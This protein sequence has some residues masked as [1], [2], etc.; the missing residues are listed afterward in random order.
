MI[1]QTRV[2][3]E[4]LYSTQVLK[5]NLCDSMMLT[6]QQE[7]IY[8]NNE[9]VNTNNFN[10]F[11]YKAKS[12][13]NTVADG[14]YEILRNTTIALQIMYL[15]NFWRSI[16]MQMI[17]CKFE[18]KLKRTNHIVFAAP[19]ATNVDVNFNN[20][21]FA[22]N[23]TKLYVP[24]IALTEKVNQNLLTKGFEGSVYWNEFKTKNESKITINQYRYFLHSIFVELNRFFVLIYSNQ[25]D[26]LVTL[27][28]L[29]VLT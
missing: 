9:I 10:Y 25:D 16:E 24:L 4:I 3:N 12:L 28:S 1:N 8:L 5:S 19:G 27:R 23:D 11:K 26:I 2:E 18:L 13:G 15:S 21:I 29:T 22:I 17:N 7:V 20:T 6:F 14:A